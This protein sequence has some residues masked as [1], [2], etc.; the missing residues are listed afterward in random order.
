MRGRKARSPEAYLQNVKDQ[1]IINEKGCWIWQGSTTQKG[2]PLNNWGGQGLV[3]RHTYMAKNGKPI[4]DDM[5]ACHS[6]DE[7][8]CCN[9]DHIFEGTNR[10]N[11]L[12]YIAKHGEI[13]NGFNSD[14]EKYP[15]GRSRIDPRIRIPTNATDEERFAI[16]KNDY[17]YH[18]ENGCWIWLR[19]VGE[20]GYGRAKYS[21]KKHMSHRIM[22]MLF[23]NKTPKDLEQLIK[24]KKVI[25]H[26]CPVEGP[27]NKACCNPNHLKIR[28]RSENAIDAMKYS[29]NRKK[30]LV[31]DEELLEW[32]YIYEFVCNE[33]GSDHDLL[34]RNNGN[35]NLEFIYNGLCN[36]GLVPK[37]VKKQYVKDV[38]KGKIFKY[39]HSEFF[40]WAASWR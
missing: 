1:C 37:G 13:K 22:W 32:L 12:D 28:T 3:Y 16:M 31:N 35:R 26:I 20:D 2:R 9:P 30:D 18:D 27:P 38:L 21:N 34:Y 7:K 19:E 36:L 33:L 23:N 6:C 10:D 17:C 8:L 5:Y 29:K 11:Q 25:G 14:P 40:D 15:D 39:F 4:A 24:D